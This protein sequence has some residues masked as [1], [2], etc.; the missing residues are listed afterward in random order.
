[1]K[2]DRQNTTKCSVCD[3]Q[4][5]KTVTTNTSSGVVGIS[6]VCEPTQNTL[7]DPNCLQFSSSRGIGI[8]DICLDGFYLNP[9][10]YCSQCRLSGCF[11]CTGAYNCAR[12]M[13][14]YSPAIDQETL[15]PKCF[16]KIQID[17]LLKNIR[18][19]LQVRF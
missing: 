19:Q 13:P 14:G 10:S 12:C 9:Y 11:S 7:Y 4:F 2:C 5:R 17:N 6:Q 1:M 8:C 16:G 15:S 3:N 18:L